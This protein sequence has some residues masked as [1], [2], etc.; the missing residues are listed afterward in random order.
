MPNLR[1]KL[2]NE[3]TYKVWIQGTNEQARK[4]RV[5]K[6]KSLSIP[7]QTSQIKDEIPNS[8]LSGTLSNILDNQEQNLGTQLQYLGNLLK[9]MFKFTFNKL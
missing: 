2:Q 6:G 8:R 5:V 3:S 9:L 1:I 7:D 4:Y